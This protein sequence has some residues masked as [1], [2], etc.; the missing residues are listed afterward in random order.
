MLKRWVRVGAV[1]QAYGKGSDRYFVVKEINASGLLHLV[2]IVEG[3]PAITADIGWKEDH[4]C[5]RS[6]RCLELEQKRGLA[7]LPSQS[8]RAPVGTTVNDFIREKKAEL[9]RFKKFCQSRADTS[10]ECSTMGDW[11]AL[12]E[13]FQN[14]CPGNSS[15]CNKGEETPSCPNL[16]N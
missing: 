12:F 5:Y 4:T 3:T 6:P 16:S 15:R 2:D 8:R 14:P 7:P 1:C 9:D 13:T 11:A 10:V